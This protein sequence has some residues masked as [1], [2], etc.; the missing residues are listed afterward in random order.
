MTD[1]LT[2]PEAAKE[3]RCTQTTAIAR[4]K[5]WDESDVAAHLG[6]EVARVKDLAACKDFPFS[7]E[8][9]RARRWLSDNFEGFALE[10]MRR[11]TPTPCALYFH[12]DKNRVLLYVGIS[13]SA[14]ARLRE[15]V[16]GSHWVDD[17]TTVRI[18][19]YATVEK[20]RAAEVRA[21]KSR[22]PLHNKMHNG[23]RNYD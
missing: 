5:V 10:S 12:Y 6:I 20:A 16:R 19:R 14:I 7:R 17:I 2:I 23:G 22:K 9:G 4:G 3:L 18:K 1:T 13:L 8:F 21:I 15:H 11:Q